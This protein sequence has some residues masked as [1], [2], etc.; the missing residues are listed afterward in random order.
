MLP[1]HPVPC[2]RLH[3]PKGSCSMGKANR[4]RSVLPIHRHVKYLYM[5]YQYVPYTSN[6][7]PYSAR[8]LAG[9]LSKHE[10]HQGHPKAL[11]RH[12]QTMVL[13]CITQWGNTA[14]NLFLIR[15]VLFFFFLFN[16]TL[17]KWQSVVLKIWY[18]EC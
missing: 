18:L 1:A 10:R 6:S 7:H 14:T 9:E 8:S 3:F 13:K 2:Q 12:R 5:S 11:F 4:K 17:N 16:I 15:E